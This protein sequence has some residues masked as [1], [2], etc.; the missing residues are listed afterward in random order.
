[1][2]LLA[3][4]VFLYLYLLL[5]MLTAYVVSKK[6][7]NTEISRNIVHICAGLG[8]ILYKIFFPTTIL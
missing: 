6:S 1:M 8:W 3:K 7:K 4:Y 2:T 5:V